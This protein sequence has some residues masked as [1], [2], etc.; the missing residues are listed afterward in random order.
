VDVCL[1]VKFI[2]FQH[3][4]LLCSNRKSMECLLE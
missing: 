1:S 2:Q 4:F 3:V